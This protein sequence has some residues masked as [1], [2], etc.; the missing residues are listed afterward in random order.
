MDPSRFARLIYRRETKSLLPYIRPVDGSALCFLALMDI[1]A[2]PPH[3]PYG[4]VKPM[5]ETGFEGAGLTNL[6]INKV[7]FAIV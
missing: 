5:H 4:L 1:C 2:P 7:V 3:H 6:N